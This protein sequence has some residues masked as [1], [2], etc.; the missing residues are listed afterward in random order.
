MHTLSSLLAFTL[1]EFQTETVWCVI[2]NSITCFAMFCHV[3]SFG[4]FDQDTVGIDLTFLFMI[5]SF[6]GTGW[7]Q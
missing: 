7:K 1:D 5:G 4:C 3:I 6:L 2:I